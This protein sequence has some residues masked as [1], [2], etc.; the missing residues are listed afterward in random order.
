LDHRPG[1]LLR[2]ASLIDLHFQAVGVYQKQMASAG[3]SSA[4]NIVWVGRFS[5]KAEPRLVDSAPLSAGRR[6]KCVSDKAF[7]LPN[8]RRHNVADGSWS[9]QNAWRDAGLGDERRTYSAG[10]AMPGSLQ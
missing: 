3:F 7:S 5:A 1:T 8:L 4:G 2:T 6:S 10:P 9:C